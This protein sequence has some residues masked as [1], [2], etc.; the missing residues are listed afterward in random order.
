MGLGRGHGSMTWNRH[1]H[2]GLIKLGFTQSKM[3]ECLYFRN[4]TILLLYVDDAII[5]DPSD[6]EIFKV[7]NELIDAGYDLTDEGT[8]DDY[9]G[10]HI[11]RD[12]AT[13]AF[14]LTQPK[15]IE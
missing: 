12:E 2:S 13:G 15:L 3:D 1:I 4:S 9:L 5:I 14:H 11:Q 8:L 7:Q 6:D 10:V